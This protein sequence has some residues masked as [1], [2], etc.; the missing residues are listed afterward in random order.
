MSFRA[1]IGSLL[2]RGM[3]FSPRRILRLRAQADPS[4]TRRD[5]AIVGGGASVATAALLGFATFVCS[6]KKYTL[7][8]LAPFEVEEFGKEARFEGWAQRRPGIPCIRNGEIEILEPRHLD[9]SPG[10]YIF[11][12][13]VTDDEAKNRELAAKR[14]GGKP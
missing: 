3:R 2:A 5:L 7:G 6:N 10:T 1:A 13:G 11:N 8:P 12:G 9:T 4:L 14:A